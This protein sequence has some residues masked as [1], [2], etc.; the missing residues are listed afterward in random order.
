M[1]L[2]CIFKIFLLSLIFTG[3]SNS[4]FAQKEDNETVY[5][6]AEYDTIFEEIKIKDAY[7]QLIHH[8]AILDTIMIKIVVK[9][10]SRIL[11]ENWKTTYSFTK[12]PDADSIGG[13]WVGVKEKGCAS[14]N[15]EDCR[16]E[17]W[18]P[19][20]PEYDL[21]TMTN[22][23]GAAWDEENELPEIIVYV[24]K[25]VE[26]QA[27]RVERIYIPAEYQTIEKYILRKRAKIIT[28]PKQH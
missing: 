28:K 15:P 3:F 25:I 5:V 23:L 2:K 8:P 7:Y 17:I 1:H 16:Y 13:R 19:E 6:S 22:Y 20:S 11:K 27:T 24:P 12:K 10:K 9:E 18:V 26:I 14:I 4:L 21:N